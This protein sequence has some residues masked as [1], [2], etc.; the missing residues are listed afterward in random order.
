ME[1]KKKN[2]EPNE[3]ELKLCLVIHQ[4]MEGKFEKWQLEAIFRI[5]K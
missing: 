4:L 1:Q 5:L 2:K 3:D